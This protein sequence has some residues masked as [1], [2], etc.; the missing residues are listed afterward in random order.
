[1]IT[2]DSLTNSRKDFLDSAFPKGSFVT[3]SKLARRFAAGGVVIGIVF[4]A[5]YW[6]DYRFNP[7]HMPPPPSWYAVIERL[8]FFFVPGLWLQILT[9]GTSDRLAWVMW[10]LAV[11]LNAP[12]YYCVGLGIS[13]V[14]ARFEPVQEKS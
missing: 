11:L 2:S 12:I 6:Y 14:A 8:M 4:L 10:L 3:T 13:A 9:I 5:T 1:M 7:L